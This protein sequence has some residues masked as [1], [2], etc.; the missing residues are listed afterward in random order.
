MPLNLF[1]NRLTDRERFP[2]PL[3]PKGLAVCT[4]RLGIWFQFRK[5]QTREERGASENPFN[6][7]L[8]P[9]L[10]FLVPSFSPCFVLEPRCF[11]SH[12]PA[13]KQATCLST[14]SAVFVCPLSFCHPKK[15]SM[16]ILPLSS[17]L[18]Y[19]FAKLCCD[20]SHGNRDHERV[21]ESG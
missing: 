10:R 2:H 21:S 9:I 4:A 7:L 6:L 3:R 12:Q 20:F 15:Q 17:A 8:F 18:I 14:T 1:P 11:P 19:T 16:G 5:K 13:S